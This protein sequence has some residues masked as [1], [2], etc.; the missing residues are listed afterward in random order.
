MAPKRTFIRKG[1]HIPIKPSRLDMMEDVADNAA[2]AGTAIAYC[3]TDWRNFTEWYSAQ[4]DKRPTE[5]DLENLKKELAKLLMSFNGIIFTAD[6]MGAV[7]EAVKDGK[8]PPCS[9]D[10]V[11]NGV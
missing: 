7:R 6:L 5:E 2:F 4:G 1:K 9:T 10:G 8:I 3:L 11:D